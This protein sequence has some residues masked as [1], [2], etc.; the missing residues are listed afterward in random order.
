M[1]TATT[2][3]A[4]RATSRTTTRS[5][6]MTAEECRSWLTS[7]GEGRLGYLSGRGPRNVVIPYALSGH[8]IVMRIPDFNEMA[9]CVPGQ[10]VTLDVTG[11]ASDDAIERVEVTGQASVCESGPVVDLSG[12]PDDGW[13]DDLRTTVVRVPMEKISGQVVSAQSYPEAS[14]CP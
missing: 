9:Q 5:R 7:H 13:P 11:F 6:A 1:T 10:Q 2:I 14:T 4:P 3:R 12:L 8:A